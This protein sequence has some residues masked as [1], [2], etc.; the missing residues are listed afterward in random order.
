M[1]IHKFLKIAF[2]DQTFW[3]Y[4]NEKVKKQNRPEK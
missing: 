1:R 2:N 4:V 3:S